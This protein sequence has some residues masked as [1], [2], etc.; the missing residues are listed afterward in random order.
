MLMLYSQNRNLSSEGVVG[1][2]LESPSEGFI[3]FGLQNYNHVSLNVYTPLLDQLVTFLV[4]GT[5][6]K[7][8]LQSLFY[9]RRTVTKNLSRESA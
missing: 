6:L 4:P 9:R 8:L 2:L 7:V 5:F 1:L 3:T